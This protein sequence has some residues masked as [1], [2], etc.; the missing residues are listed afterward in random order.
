MIG[1]SPTTLGDISTLDIIMIGVSLTTLGDFH[2]L[3]HS[4]KIVAEIQ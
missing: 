1:V 4:Q 3:N 2:G